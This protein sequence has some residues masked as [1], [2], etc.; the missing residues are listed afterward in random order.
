MHRRLRLLCCAAG[1]LLA[2]CAG[3]RHG[4]PSGAHRRAPETLEQRLET[5]SRQHTIQERQ[6]SPEEIRAEIQDLQQQREDLL[7]RFTPEYPDVVLIDGQIQHL[8]Q[9]L[10]KVENAGPGP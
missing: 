5:L 8:R 7:K 3:T 9:E 4:P 10:R 2:A 6:R 1:I